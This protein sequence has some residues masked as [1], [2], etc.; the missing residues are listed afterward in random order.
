MLHV[1]VGLVPVCTTVGKAVSDPT[2]IAG[3]V[4]A[5]AVR[6]ASTPTA[7]MAAAAAVR[8]LVFMMARVV[9]TGDLQ[10]GS[11]RER[12]AED[13]WSVLPAVWGLLQRTRAD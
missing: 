13:T 11:E 12:I 10:R 7:R 9:I 8:W 2:G 3:M 5:R 4:W 1:S 6:V